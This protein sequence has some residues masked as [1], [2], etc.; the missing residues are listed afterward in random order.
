MIFYFLF[1]LNEQRAGGGGGGEVGAARLFFSS[2]IFPGSA[3]HE[4]DWPP[5]KIVFFRVGNQCAECKKQQL[6]RMS[7]CVVICL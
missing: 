3:N 2:F 4:R 5:C 7:R 6:L 1:S